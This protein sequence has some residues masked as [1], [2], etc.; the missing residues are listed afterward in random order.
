[1]IEL[2]MPLGLLGLLGIAVLIIIYILKPNYQQKIV[3]STYVWKLSL[4][5]RKRRIPIQRFRNILTF[6]CQ[7][8]ILACCAFLLAQPFLVEQKPGEYTEK[9]FIVDASASMRVENESGITRFERAVSQ[10]RE[11]SFET[12]SQNGTVSVILAGSDAEVILQNVQSAGENELDTALDKL[13]SS[14]EMQCSYGSADMEGAVSLAQQM[15]DVH[16]AAEV[17]LYTATEYIEKGEISVVNVAEEGEWNA[18][19]LDVTA[20]LDEQNFY[21]FEIEAACFGRSQEIVVHCNVT[22][23]NNTAGANVTMSK[24]VMF[25]Y[26]EQ[27][28]TVVFTAA[29]AGNADNGVY[30]YESVQAYVEVSDSF[31]DDN[32]FYLYGGAKPTLKVL[33]SSSLPNHYFSEFFLALRE[34]VKDTWTIDLDEVKVS[35]RN[36][37]IT[38]GYDFYIYE[39][40]VPETLPSDGVVFLSDPDIA[41]QGGGFT[42]ERVVEVDKNTQLVATGSHAITEGVTAANITAAK[43]VK[44]SPE[45]GYTELMECDGDPVLMVKEDGVMKVVVLTLDLN[46]SNL[47]LLPDFLFLLYNSFDYF[48]PPTIS[49]YSVEVGDTVTLNARGP[50]LEL[51]APGSDKIERYEA[52]PVELTVT[53]PSTYTVSQRTPRGENLIEQFFVHIPNAES[54]I[55]SAVD[56]LPLLYVPELEENDDLDLLL[57]IAICLVALLFIEWWLQSRENF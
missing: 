35:Q 27:Q 15:V 26:A 23:V 46:Y 29:D 51:N 1:M 20:T 34:S 12:L 24:R 13:V 9:I 30:A 36:Q 14:G 48:L 19:V 7:M 57:Y 8:L 44:I 41:P 5:Y 3:S 37:I 55:T 25:D 2:L 56:A 49:S 43:Y 45:E 50:Y 16:P 11:A 6:I 32:T 52:F 18:A 47:A 39:H 28:Q 42:R 21:R 31:E 38:S 10:V 53:R 22:G 4:K 40:M 33:Y 17:V 54:D